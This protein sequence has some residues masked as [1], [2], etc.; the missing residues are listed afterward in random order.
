VAERFDDAVVGAGIVG[1]A[2][3]YHLARRGRRVAVFERSPRAQGASVRNFGM[4]WPIGQPPGPRADL[5]LRSRAVW[6]EVLAAAGLW[7]DPVG[8]LHLAY[9]PDEAAVIEEFV[10]IARGHGFE[11]SIVSPAEVRR[12]APVVRDDGLIAG[13]WSATEV[14]VDPRAV[15]A[16]MP[17][18]LAERYGVTFHFGVAVT[19]YHA[20]AGTAGWR[21]FAAERLWVCS[22]ADLETL[23]P[24][25]LGAAG[26]TPCKLQMMRT[27]PVGWRLGPMLAAGLTLKHYQA[28]AACPSLPALRDRFAR[29]YPEHE[30]FG[31]HVM[32]SQNGA[33]ELV[34]GD[35]HEYGPAVTPFDNPTIDRLILDYLHTFVDIPDLTIGA[36]WHGVYVKHPTEPFV[37]LEP[38]AGVT[39][40]VGV[41]GA[42]MTLSFGLAEQVV[43]ERLG[44]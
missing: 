4:L 23:Y 18:F 41:G 31:I 11:G 35:S 30:R 7:H 25:A 33:G 39:A 19:D 29:E 16:G 38:A 40:T 32:A 10:A 28:F 15:I 12:K 17:A 21:P 5:A 9:R 22:G 42:G 3:A 14:C 1:L 27:P 36:R 44:R 24:A 43:A 26:L 20:P 8:S 2:H 13:L 37:V 6:L 34:L